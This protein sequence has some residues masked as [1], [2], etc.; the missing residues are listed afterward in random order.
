[1]VYNLTASALSLYTLYV[2]CKELYQ[3]ESTFEPQTTEQLKFAY[4]IYWHVKKLELLDTVFM[5][6]RH[7]Q[8]QISFL[9]VY[10]HGSMLLLSD[11][12]CNFYPYVSIATYLGLNS[13]VHV[14]L[15][16]YYGLSALYPDNPPQWKTILTQF[17]IIQFFID[18]VHA[19]IGYMYH[20][21]CVFGIFYC[22][23]MIIL[24]SNFYL[25]AY[26]KEQSSL[27]KNKSDTISNKK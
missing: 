12:S 18:L 22:L 23:A 4:R 17:Q 9:H 25:K 8:R 2:F 10:H 11:V 14:L 19:T 15:Y 13:A 21:F 24:F 20:N 5:V 6:L 1:M 26:S 27:A 3:T 7:K 16:F